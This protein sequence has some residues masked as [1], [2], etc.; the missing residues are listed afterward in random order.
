VTHSIYHHQDGIWDAGQKERYLGELM[1]SARAHREREMEAAV[2]EDYVSSR[3]EQ[4]P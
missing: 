1:A 3:A 2:S 4:D